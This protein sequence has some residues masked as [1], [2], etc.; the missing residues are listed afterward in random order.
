MMF[1]VKQIRKNIDQKAYFKL[2][3]KENL[4]DGQKGMKKTFPNK[5]PTNQMK[6]S[7]YLSL[8][9]TKT[10]FGHHK[11]ISSLKR[12]NFNYKTIFTEI[13]QDN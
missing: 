12:P 2:N 13:A 5:Q 11:A 4:G 8:L 1:V 3:R 10:T 7:I 6:T 9:I